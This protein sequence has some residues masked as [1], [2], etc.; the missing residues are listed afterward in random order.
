MIG[1]WLCNPPILAL[2]E[3]NT[4]SQQSINPKI[5]CKQLKQHICDCIKIEKENLIAMI[6]FLSMKNTLAKLDMSIIWFC[7]I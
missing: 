5:F 3:I 7:T 1:F 2:L 4:R 6:S